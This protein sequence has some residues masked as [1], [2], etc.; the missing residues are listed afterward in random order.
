MTETS[1]G[2]RNALRTRTHI[3]RV[4]FEEIYRNG[5]RGA[6]VNEIIKKAATTK[7]AFFHHFET[8]ESL[9]YVIVDELIEDL[10]IERWVRPLDDYDD[11]LEGIVRNFKK[12]VEQTPDDHLGLGCPLNNLIQEMSP[13]D[14]IFAEKLNRAL[15]TWIDGVERHLKRAR[16]QGYLRPRA[17]V[18]RL[19]EFVVMSHEGAFGMVKAIQ[20]RRVFNGLIDSLKTHLAAERP[21]SRRSVITTHA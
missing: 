11:P 5:Y 14:Q 7:G 6:S 15:L 10:I 12:I 8:K 17:N 20:D 13:T 3:L 18:R 9:G 2:S 21:V 1:Q 19:A 16:R 4:A